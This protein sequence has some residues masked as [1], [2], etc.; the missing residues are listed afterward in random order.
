MC[1]GSVTSLPPSLEDP[2]LKGSTPSPYVANFRPA[3]GALVPN[4]TPSCEGDLFP[5]ASGLLLRTEGLNPGVFAPLNPTPS[6]SPDSVL[7][8]YSLLSLDT[9]VGGLVLNP[10]NSRG[11]EMC[12]ISWGVPRVLGLGP[13]LG[14][15][16]ALTAWACMRVWEESAEEGWEDVEKLRGR[17]GLARGE[18]DGGEGAVNE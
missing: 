5:A 10:P 8:P 7:R 18:V 6:P 13:R 11:V 4:L 12:L 15:L 14:L 1:S 3:L 9:I 16:D 2:L 17:F